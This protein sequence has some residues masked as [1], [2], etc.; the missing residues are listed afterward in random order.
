MVGKCNV[1]AC[2]LLSAFLPCSLV[3]LLMAPSYDHQNSSPSWLESSAVASV[4]SE[5]HQKGFHVPVLD[6][7]C[8][9]L[10]LV[11]WSV[12][13]CRWETL[14]VMPILF[15]HNRIAVSRFLAQEKTWCRSWGLD[16]L[17]TVPRS[18]RIRWVLYLFSL[19]LYQYPK[20]WR[21]VPRTYP[22]SHV[23]L[24][25]AYLYG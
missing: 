25:T 7:A 13:A 24:W 14:Y 12:R 17:T 22:A 21:T 1:N 6:A 18:G 23:I 10:V 5:G 16:S 8:Q 19:C 15:L 20:F 9:G 2:R 3:P 11:V 4:G